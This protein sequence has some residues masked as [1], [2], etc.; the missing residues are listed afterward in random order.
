MRQPLQKRVKEQGEDS[1]YW[2]EPTETLSIP[3]PEW[4]RTLSK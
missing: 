3:V 2:I 4:H 1:G